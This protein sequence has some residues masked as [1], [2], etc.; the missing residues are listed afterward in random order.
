[1]HPTAAKAGRLPHRVK[2]GHD[3]TVGPQ[4]AGA[5]VF[6]DGTERLAREDIELD[7]DQRPGL[8]VEYRVGRATR[9]SLSPTYLQASWRSR[10]RSNST[11]FEGLPLTATGLSDRV[12][13]ISASP[14]QARSAAGLSGHPNPGARSCQ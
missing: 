7:G 1:M 8:R 2:S 3:G 12:G 14:G 4:G 10:L 9:M 13:M 11:V 6:L 5:Q